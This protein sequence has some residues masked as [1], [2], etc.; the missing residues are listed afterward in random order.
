MPVFALAFIAGLSAYFLEGTLRHLLLAL[1]VGMILAVAL[2]HGVRLL[3]TAISDKIASRLE[4][5][6]DEFALAIAPKLP[7]PKPATPVLTSTGSSITGTPLPPTPPELPN[8]Q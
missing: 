2:D 8:K 7:A 5:A 3:F 4:L 1:S 6:R